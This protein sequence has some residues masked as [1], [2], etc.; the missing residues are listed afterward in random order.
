MLGLH[1]TPEGNIR[2]DVDFVIQDATKIDILRRHLP[3]IREKLGFTEVTTERQVRQHDRYQRVFRNENN[4]IRSIIA[5]RWTGLQLSEG[6]VT[7]I[8]FR[9]PRFTIPV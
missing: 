7:T 1:L 6:V 9:D 8:R 2:K 5:R 3:G 4:S